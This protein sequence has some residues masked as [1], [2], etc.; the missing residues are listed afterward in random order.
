MRYLSY[1][2]FRKEHLSLIC[3]A[4]GIIN[5]RSI[6]Q[7]DD[8]RINKEEAFLFMVYRI[9]HSTTFEEEYGGT[10]DDLS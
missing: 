10:N 6:I 4:F 8:C 9:S 7:S 5:I 3:T 1:F 2:R